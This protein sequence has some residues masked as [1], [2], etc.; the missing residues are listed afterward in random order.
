MADPVYL[1][2]APQWVRS[3]AHDQWNDD[4]FP[5]YTGSGPRRKLHEVYDTFT[6]DGRLIEGPE[7]A[8]VVP[9]SA[10]EGL[11]VSTPSD[12]ERREA[13]NAWRAKRAKEA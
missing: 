13:W 9:L 10:R 6:W 5:F 11:A 2:N 8:V 3:W 12:E 1:R 4:S 7:G